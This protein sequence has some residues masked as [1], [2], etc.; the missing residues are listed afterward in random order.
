MRSFHKI[1]LLTF[2]VAILMVTYFAIANFSIFEKFINKSRVENIVEATSIITP[3]PTLPTVSDFR[4]DGGFET[5]SKPSKAFKEISWLSIFTGSPVGY[6]SS[7]APSPCTSS[8][9]R[10]EERINWVSQTP[11]GVLVTNN[12][13]Y[14]WKDE[15][16][17]INRFSFKTV[18]HNN[19][20][21]QFTGHF[22]SS[23]NYEETKPKD[24]VL[25]GRLTK[26]VDG[27]IAAEEDVNFNWFSWGEV[28]S[29]TYSHKKPKSK[30]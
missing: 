20:S 25:I 18:T 8:T 12:Y 15:N 21:Y 16:L 6:G 17:S 9:P 13:K 19:Q 4:P 23:G 27:K 22:T 11:H 26:I 7:C 1:G 5:N 10:V 29:E 3:T 24:T 2:G 30:K 14:A 28:D